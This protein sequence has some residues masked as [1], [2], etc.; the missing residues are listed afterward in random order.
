MEG[1]KKEFGKPSVQA[2]GL[3]KACLKGMV[4]VA[5]GKHLNGKGKASLVMWREAWREM[6]CFTAIA[7]FSDVNRLRRKDISEDGDT[8][9]IVF[10]VR[11][12]V[13]YH[14]TQTAFLIANETR[15]CPVKLTKMY[16]DLLPHDQEGFM[17][18]D[19]SVRFAHTKA[20]SYSACRRLQKSLLRK[21]G[22]DP[23]PF[24]L[25]L[26][27]VGAMKYLENAEISDPDMRYIVGW[28]EGSTQPSHYAKTAMGKYLKVAR[29]LKLF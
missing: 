18:P 28:A 9:K 1:N 20:A 22:L 7:R 19:L 5:I 17:I 26:A 27:R 29:K 16:L 10:N 4:N 24:G 13:Q 15:Y 6:V 14:K 25:H 3:S 21:L 2:E 12:N 11:K 23:G 8:V